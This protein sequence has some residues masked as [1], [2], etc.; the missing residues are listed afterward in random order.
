[1]DYIEADLSTLPHAGRGAFTRHILE[2][3]Q[4]VV[5]VPLLQ[6]PRYL[7]D[8]YEGTWQGN[9]YEA[10]RDRPP[11]QTQLI[12]NYCFGHAE[13]SLLLCPYGSGASLINHSRKGANVRLRWSKKVNRRPEW[14]NMSVP[15]WIDDK[16]GLTMDVIALREILPGEEI[17]LDYGDAWEAAWQVHVAQW[18]PP[19]EAVWYRPAM[20]LNEDAD[21]IVRI[22]S[23]G[24]YG[25]L[26]EVLCR[27]RFRQFQGMSAKANSLHSCAVVDRYQGPDGAYRYRAEIFEEE[28]D[29]EEEAA[30]LCSHIAV[31]VLWDLPR[32]AFWFEDTMYSR[33][34]LQHWSFRHEMGIPDD[35]F[36]QDWK[37]KR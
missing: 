7:Y 12:I 30:G 16:A 32:D 31:E 26:V 3:G 14:F 17:L 5:P 2:A 23:E 29:D 21:L 6:F 8:M 11:V 18:Q 20:E 36:P 37:D 24:S 25:G 28:T 9:H 27:E 10:A 1:M 19:P 13:S 4:V 15:E 22:S 34:H 33:D 35:M